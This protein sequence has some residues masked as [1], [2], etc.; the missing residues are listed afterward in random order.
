MQCDKKQ[1]KF[2]FRSK[3]VK[4][5]ISFQKQ[6][7]MGGKKWNWIRFDFTKHHAEFI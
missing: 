2:G 3:A 6:I 1:I 7:A 4:F 5:R